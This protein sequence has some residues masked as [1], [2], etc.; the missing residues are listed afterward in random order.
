MV[1]QYKLWCCSQLSKASTYKSKLTT[2]HFQHTIRFWFALLK[3]RRNHIFQ[4]AGWGRKLPNLHRNEPKHQNYEVP[5]LVY[6]IRISSVLS[7]FV[8][9]LWRTMHDVRI[10]KIDQKNPEGIL[11]VLSSEKTT[12]KNETPHTQNQPSLIM[13][14]FSKSDQRQRGS[15]QNNRCIFK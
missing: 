1:L 6:F 11:E 7:G 13:T 2:F 5:Y 3:L 9:P 4:L 10:Y 15:S 14:L 8:V 12:N